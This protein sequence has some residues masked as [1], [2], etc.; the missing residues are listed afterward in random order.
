MR[1]LPPLCPRRLRAQHRRLARQREV[2]PAPIAVGDAVVGRLQRGQP[3]HHAQVAADVVGERGG[4]SRRG[5]RMREPP[6]PAGPG[7]AGLAG[8]SAARPRTRSGSPQAGH[9]GCRTSSWLSALRSRV[10]RATI[11][12]VSR[13]DAPCTASTGSS[14]ASSPAAIGGQAGQRP[15]GRAAGS[16]RSGPARRGSV[17]TCSF[18]C[19]RC[20]RQSQQP[21]RP[22]HEV[23]AER[24]RRRRVAG[25]ASTLARRPGGAR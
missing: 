14:A 20:R 5:A 6:G 21:V 9:C 12:P 4:T 13:G 3:G 19:Q 18:S 7:A 10:S 11:R 25:S 8:R 2:V 16:G 1:P 23:R 22:G 15:R 17:S 24:T